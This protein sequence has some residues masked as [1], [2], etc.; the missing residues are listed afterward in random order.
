MIVNG[1][2]GARN[3]AWAI[4]SQVHDFLWLITAIGGVVATVLLIAF[5]A[6]S[7]SIIQPANLPPPD[8][9]PANQEELAAQRRVAEERLMREQ[10]IKKREAELKMRIEEELNRRL[11]EKRRTKSADDVT[12]SALKDFL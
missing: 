10:E 9:K 8:Q 11:E 1:S 6:P 2:A 4:V 3:P 12:R 5:Y 7:F